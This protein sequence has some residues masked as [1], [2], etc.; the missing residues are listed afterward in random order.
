M[1]QAQFRLN[2]TTVCNI[3]EVLNDE[4][5]VGDFLQF[6]SIGEYEEAGD[7]ITDLIEKFEGEMVEVLKVSED[8]NEWG[9]HYY[10]VINSEGDIVSATDHEFSKVYREI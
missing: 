9:E 10:L 4:I 6:K 2:K 3:R 1:K 7:E 8:T 5:R